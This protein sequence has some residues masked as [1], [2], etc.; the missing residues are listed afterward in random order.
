VLAQH[1]QNPSRKHLAAAKHVWKYLV[2]TEYYAICATALRTES[3]SYITEGEA[4]EAGV[5]PLFFSA[6]YAAFA[7][8]QPGTPLH[9]VYVN[10]ISHLTLRHLLTHLGC[11]YNR[12]M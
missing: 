10:C 5:E 4:I 9:R 11:V 12:S 3:A 8:C 2:G 7:N 1:L 6:S